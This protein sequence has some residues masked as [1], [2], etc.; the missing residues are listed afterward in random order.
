MPGPAR[1]ETVELVKS[2]IPLFCGVYTL[3]SRRRGPGG[4]IGGEKV[5]KATEPAHRYAPVCAITRKYSNLQGEDVFY[6]KQS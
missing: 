3:E 4:A 5:E 1:G 6:R 2:N